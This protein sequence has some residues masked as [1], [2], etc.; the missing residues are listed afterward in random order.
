MLPVMM[1]RSGSNMPAAVSSLWARAFASP[2]HFS[3]VGQR[4]QTAAKKMILHPEGNTT[5]TTRFC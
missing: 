4:H 5:V 1:A 2:G 3:R